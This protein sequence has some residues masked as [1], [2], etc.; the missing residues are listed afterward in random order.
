MVFHLRDGANYYGVKFG[1][2]RVDPFHVDE[3]DFDGLN[4]VDGVGVVDGDKT[5]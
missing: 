4:G 2:S 1:G 3:A 5:G